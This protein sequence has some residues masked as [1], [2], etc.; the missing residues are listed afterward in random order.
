MNNLIQNAIKTHDGIILISRHRHDFVT[1]NDYMLDGGLDYSRMSYPREYKD[2]FEMLFLYEND[3]I[4]IISKKLVWG[5]NNNGK[6]Q[7]VK[8]CDLELNHLKNILKTQNLSDIYI[9]TIKYI[10]EEKVS[11]LRYKKIIKIKNV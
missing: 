7:Y 1:Y 4:D 9:N 5:K 2:E 10:I 3:P 11:L 8:L 6:I